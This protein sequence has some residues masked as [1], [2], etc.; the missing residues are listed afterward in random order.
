M[1]W[2]PTCDETACVRV[3]WAWGII[4]VVVEGWDIDEVNYFIEIS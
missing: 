4:V 2:I 1:Y 3:L